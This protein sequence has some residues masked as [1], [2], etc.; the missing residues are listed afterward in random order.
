MRPSITVVGLGPAG[1]DL[2]APGARRLL[3]EAEAAFLRTSRHP[4]AA[5][6]PGMPSFDHHYEEA[7]TF[8]EVYA[9]IVADLVT[10]AQ[11]V[12]AS[13]RSVVYGVPGSPLVAERTVDLLREDPRVD[14]TV[15]PAVSFVDLA[16]ARLGVDPVAVGAR[17]VDGT[18][19]A[20]QAAGQRGP[21]LVAQCWSVDVLSAV[22]LAVGDA[23]VATAATH[24]ATAATAATHTATV[25]HHLGLADEAV[26][27]VPW[28]EL[29]R[30]VAPDHLT[31]IWLPFPGAAVA[32]EIV[33]L[34]ELSRRLR[35]ECPW[36]RRQTH[37]SLARYLLEECY[38]ALDAI[39]ALG[40]AAAAGAEPRTSVVRHT[41]AAAGADVGAAAAA[42]EEELG[43]VLFQ[44][45]FHARLG[46]EEGWFTLA[47]VARGVHDK[48]VARHPHVFGDVVAE[49]AAA[50]ASNWEEIKKRE[51]GRESVTDG[52]PAALPA[53]ALAATLQRKAAGAVPGVAEPA[54][55]DVR[56][57]ADEALRALPAG[58]G[59]EEPPVQGA[60][61]TAGALLWAITDL[62]RRAGIEPE[63]ALRAAAQRF[64]ARLRAAEGLEP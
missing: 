59:P 5:G 18:R 22:K 57:V 49:D 37:A 30:A 32:A 54:L 26:V 36:D 27:T 20:E 21:M 31:T 28:H 56:A 24:T 14:L 45:C 35:A 17:L 33:A 51:K 62:V 6:L 7:A 61:E 23:L 47:D 55:A 42:L 25:L 52:I 29:D 15:V 10:A 48:L 8:E 12:A 64:R 63:D 44:V 9:R 40:Q 19:F 3:L 46:A 60:T 1:D 53:L 13:E 43:D 58:A 11:V 50:V 34:D 38:E 16:W 41:A 39:D 4:A 2:T